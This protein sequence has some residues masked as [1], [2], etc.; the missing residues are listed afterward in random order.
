ME[1]INWWAILVAGIA[2]M[3]LGMI[4]YGPFLFG[5]TWMKIIGVD[6]ATTP[7]E[8]IKA[9]QKRMFPFYLLQFVVTLVTLYVLANYISLYET[10]SGQF[11]AIA[12]ITTALWIWLGFVMPLA[13]GGAVWSGKSKKLMLAMFLTTAGYQLVAFVMFGAIL[14]GWQ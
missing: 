9:E 1:I 14:G 12:G 8:K 2:S 13:L 5:K 10:V 3:V 4:W 6:L 11:G 7:P